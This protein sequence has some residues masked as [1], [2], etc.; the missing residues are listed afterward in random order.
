MN[1]KLK[2]FY[3]PEDTPSGR[4]PFHGLGELLE[5]DL[6]DDSV[7]VTYVQS[8]CLIEP[9]EQYI[10]REDFPQD[11][12]Y[13]K[14]FYNPKVSKP[15]QLSQATQPTQTVLY[16]NHSQDKESQSQKTQPKSTRG[17][18]TVAHKEPIW[19]N[20]P[21]ADADQG[22]FVPSSVVSQSSMPPTEDLSKKRNRADKDSLEDELNSLLEEGIE[23]TENK[24]Q[25]LRKPA[26]SSL[27][28]QE[29][30]VSKKKSNV[31]VIYLGSDDEFDAGSATK[32]AKSST[33]S[34]LFDTA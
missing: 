5:T 3:R 20:S 27:V 7:P 10:A 1:M 28:S 23:K 32:K 11:V 34:M 8:K 25:R 12:Y 15:P 4:K 29:P 9:Y 24:R 33:V 17:K 31:E 19:L 14:D 18:P 13:Y 26:E 2:W 21:P 16:K 22:S 30:T 6:Y